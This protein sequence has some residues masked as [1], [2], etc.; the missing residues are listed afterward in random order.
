[1]THR[2][3]KHLGQ[4]FLTSEKIVLDMVHAAGVTTADTVL[5]IGPGKGVLTRALLTHARRVVAI[6]KDS[7]LVVLLNETFAHEIREGRLVLIENDIRDVLSKDTGLLPKTFKVVANIPYYITGEIIE[8]VLSGAHQPET[9][10]LLVQKEVAQRIVARDSAE[11]ILSIAVK[12]YGVPRIARLVPKSFFTPRPKVDSAILVIDHISRKHFADA[13]EARFFA[14]VKQGFAHKRK[15]LAS[16]LEGLVAKDAFASFAEERGLPEG[17]RAEELS[18]EDWLALTRK[19][20]S[21]Q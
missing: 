13:D 1:M 18:L 11:S 19:A 2:A 9:A 14:L 6:E 15:K 21:R 3:K 5:E 10:A 12:A 4:N 16:N 20:S 17:A 8:R 7:E